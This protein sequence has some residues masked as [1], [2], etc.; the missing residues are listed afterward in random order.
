MKKGVISKT[1][2][3][4]NI[5]ILHITNF[6]DKHIKKKNIL[7]TGRMHPGESNSSH[8]LQGFI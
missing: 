3:G 5:P 6:E 1:L 8:M 7:I 2:S 4:V